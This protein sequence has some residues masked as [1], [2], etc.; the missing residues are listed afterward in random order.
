LRIHRCE[1]TN[2]IDSH[3]KGESLKDVIM[4]KTDCL[5][6]KAPQQFREISYVQLADSLVLHHSPGI[7]KAVVTVNRST[8]DSGSIGNKYFKRIGIVVT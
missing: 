6:H 8:R 5:L 2:S 1:F 7:A 3:T 4:D